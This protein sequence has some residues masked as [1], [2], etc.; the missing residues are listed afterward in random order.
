MAGLPVSGFSGTL[1]D[2]YSLPPAHAAA[3]VVR[4]KTGTLTG[5]NSLAGTT[6][7]ADGRLLVFVV[8]SDE[9][10]VGG[11]TLARRA[12]DRVA[13]ALTACGCR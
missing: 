12:S 9:V 5:V 3:G 10:P 1:A 6:V 7:D 13:A 2:R 11:T 8:M 4:A